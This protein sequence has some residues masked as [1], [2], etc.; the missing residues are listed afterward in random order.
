VIAYPRGSM[1][2]LVTPGVT[3]FLVDGVEAAAACV[4]RAVAL[5]RAAIR[6]VAAERFGKDRM[7]DDYLGVYRRLLGAA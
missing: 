6:A 5:D 2:E 3:G 1:P 4:D 7:V